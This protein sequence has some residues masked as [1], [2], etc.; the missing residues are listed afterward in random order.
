MTKRGMDWLSAAADDPDKCRA[1]WED[2]LRSPQ[3]FSTGRHFDVVVIDQRI[4]VET[5]DQLQRWVMPTGA[6]I[7]DT[8]AKQVGFFLASGSRDRFERALAREAA[9]GTMPAYKYLELGSCVVV[10]GPM[11]LA[12]DRY[13]WLNP[14]GRLAEAFPLRVIALAV[15]L[16]ASARLV[17]RV[18]RYGERYP[19]A[20]AAIAEEAA[21]A[22]ADAG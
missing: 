9:D 20:E 6:V 21:E 19:T 22:H 1:R 3:T 8:R 5:F 16:V 10:P 13:Q 17:E 11:P 4:G 7:V 18:D 2:D 14:P 15:L 12:S